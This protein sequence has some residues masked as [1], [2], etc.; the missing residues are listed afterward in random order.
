MKVLKNIITVCVLC[1]SIIGFTACEKIEKGTPPAIKKLIRETNKMSGCLGRVVEY[2]YNNEY[3][4]CFE[5]HP[6]HFDGNTIYYDEK[7]K[8]LWEFGGGWGSKPLEGFYEKAI[9]KRVIWKAK[10]W[11]D[12]KHE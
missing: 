4:Y 12:I 10:D 8:K 9:F 11:Y 5:H 6:D 7:G 2:E 3:I 1:A